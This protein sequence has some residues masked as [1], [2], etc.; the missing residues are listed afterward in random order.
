M[1]KPFDQF[2]RE[3]VT[4]FHSPELLALWLERKGD[5]DGAHRIVQEILSSSAARVHAYLHRVEGDN[6][7]AAYWYNRAGVSFYHGPLKEEWEMLVHTFLREIERKN[8]N[9]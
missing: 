4:A 7:N 9:D 3:E 6:G 1:K 2:S 5:W 8:P